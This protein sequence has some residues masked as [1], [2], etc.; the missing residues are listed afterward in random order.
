M[1]FV[2]LAVALAFGVA[3]VLTTAFYALFIVIGAL[4]AA[5]A[6]QLGAPLPIQ[7]IVFAVTSVAGVVLARPPLMHYVS[8]RRTPELL[9]GAQ[10][11]VGQEAPVVEDIKDAHTAGHV[12]IGGERWPAVAED[13][14]FI[15]AG[16]TVRVTG[17]RQA[18]LVV[19]LVS[20]PP[21]P[22]PTAEAQPTTTQKEG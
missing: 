9:S 11:M 13:G 5:I 6:A 2:W 8:R 4:A 7:V 10:A 15:A 20:P 18:T 3:E 19:S 16:S 14:S 17:L 21:E 1:T 22:P 12:R